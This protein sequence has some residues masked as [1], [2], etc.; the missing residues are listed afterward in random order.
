MEDRNRIGRWLLI[1]LAAALLCGPV[2]CIGVQ[3]PTF[4]FWSD[5]KGP[6]QGGSG[7]A[8]KTGEACSHHW[9]GVVALGDA[10]IET[11]AKNGGITKVVSA[12]YHMTNYIVMGTY[13]TIVRGN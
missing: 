2:G 6:L 7:K 13:C 11:A 1:A 9:A 8:Q 12:D 5:V 4:G 3:G 10:S